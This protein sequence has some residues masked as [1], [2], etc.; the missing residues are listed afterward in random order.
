MQAPCILGSVSVW[1]KLSGAAK[2]VFDGTIRPVLLAAVIFHALFCIP[3]LCRG[4]DRPECPKQR[5]ESAVE[6]PSFPSRYIVSNLNTFLFQRNRVLEI[7]KGSA[8]FKWL[9]TGH[10]QRDFFPER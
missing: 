5:I 3:S 6:L 7:A 10:K 8:A 9:T 4:P 2:Q 1:Q